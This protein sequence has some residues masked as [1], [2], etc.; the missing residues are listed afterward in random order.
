MTTAQECSIYESIEIGGVDADELQAILQRVINDFKTAYSSFRGNEENR[1]VCCH[2]HLV[3]GSRTISPM[4]RMKHFPPRTKHFVSKWLKVMNASRT[5]F[6]DNC[7]RAIAQRTAFLSI[8]SIEWDLR[9]ESM[10]HLLFFFQLLRIFGPVLHR[11]KL[12]TVIDQCAPALFD[13]MDDVLKKDELLFEEYEQHR[14][15][16]WLLTM[17]NIIA[18]LTWVEQLRQRIHQRDDLGQRIPHREQNLLKRLDEFIER[19]NREWMEQF[20]KEDLLHL[21]EPLLRQDRHYYIV[22]MKIEVSHWRSFLTDRYRPSFSF[23]L[24]CTR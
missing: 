7:S 23:S 11:P 17:P 16:S 22:N 12:K 24:P 1:S 9:I 6:V 3:Q 10:L 20:Q 2:F 5:S 19:T 18:D 14:R 8:R 4:T 15:H 21:N 13:A